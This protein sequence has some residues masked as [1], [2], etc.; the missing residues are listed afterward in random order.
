M[1]EEIE[2]SVTDV[3]AEFTAVPSSL[4]TAVECWDETEP[5]GG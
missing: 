3:A 2:T 4:A 1:S 5:W